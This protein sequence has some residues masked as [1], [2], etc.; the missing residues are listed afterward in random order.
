[1]CV[2]V[3]ACVCVCVCKRVSVRNR[4]VC[5]VIEREVT[6]DLALLALAVV[7]YHIHVGHPGHSFSEALGVLLSRQQE[8]LKLLVYEALSY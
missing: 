3:R 7:V 5:S 2:C 1:V 6:C 8:G 4:G